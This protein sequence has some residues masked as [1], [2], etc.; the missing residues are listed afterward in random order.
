[1]LWAHHLSTEARASI[2]FPIPSMPREPDYHALATDPLYR[3][4]ASCTSCHYV[5]QT[6]TSEGVPLWGG[7]KM[8]RVEVNM[9]DV[10]DA[11]QHP[12]WSF[13]YYYNANLR[14]SRYEHHEGQYDEVCGSKRY[15]KA[16][17]VVMASDGWTYLAS[18]GEC[19]KCSKGFLGAV[20]SDWLADGGH[21]VGNTTVRG[22]AVQEWFKQG[23]SDNHYYFTQPHDLPVRYMEHK[24][25]KLK[26]WDFD[27][28]TYSTAP[29][30]DTLFQ[31]PS[32]CTARCTDAACL[33]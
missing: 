32:G 19:C 17:T 13:S 14:A 12:K 26:Q 25:G 3:E 28:T 20:R 23:A 2:T 9:T 31:Q 24:N 16:C 4:Q 10:S 18:G 6:P 29:L 22:Y 27:L 21:Y 5:T 7:A 1:M 33:L 8:Y 11:P 30:P 15:G